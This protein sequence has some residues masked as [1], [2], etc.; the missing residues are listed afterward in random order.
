MLEF[1]MLSN[2]THREFRRAAVEEANGLLKSKIQLP[3]SMVGSVGNTSQLPKLDCALD[4][5]P[6]GRASHPR[7]RCCIT[8]GCSIEDRFHGPH[9]TEK[10]FP[11]LVIEE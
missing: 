5:S 1:H 8:N 11:S 10:L 9:I 7:S 2:G 6:Q 4:Q 3:F